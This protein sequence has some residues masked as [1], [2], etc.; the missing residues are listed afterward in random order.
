MRK[1]RILVCLSLM[2]M[3]Y[4]GWALLTPPLK[5]QAAA[6]CTDPND[7]ASCGSDPNWYCCMYSS[8]CRDDGYP[9]YCY[10]NNCPPNPN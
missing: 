2:S 6:C 3:V 4:G 9:G 8:N 5:A 1:V 10:L 7:Y